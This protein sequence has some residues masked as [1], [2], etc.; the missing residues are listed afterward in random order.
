M[1]SSLPFSFSLS[2]FSLGREGRKTKTKER[3]EKGRKERKGE[4][5]TKS[6]RDSKVSEELTTRQGL[7]N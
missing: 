5:T 6:E 4:G 2:F 1:L 3:K 7:L